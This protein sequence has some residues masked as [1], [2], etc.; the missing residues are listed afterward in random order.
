MFGIYGCEY[1]RRNAR[2]ASGQSESAGSLIPTLR[3]TPQADPARFQQVSINRSTV[4]ELER[5][6]MLHLQTAALLILAS[7]AVL[8]LIYLGKLIL[9]VV[10][11]SILLSF[12]LAP[13]VDAWCEFNIPRAVGSLL[14]VFCWSA[15]SA[16]PATRPTAAPWTSCRSC[17]STRP[18]F[19][20]WAP[21]SANRRSRSKRPP[22]P[23]CRRIARTTRNV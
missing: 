6:R 13:I 16:S 7:A 5:R 4:A 14:A 2:S 23:C 3:R 9:V 1:H 18:G 22:R 21:R 19:R 12:V 11:I 17:L 15:H 10:L 8:T 20:R